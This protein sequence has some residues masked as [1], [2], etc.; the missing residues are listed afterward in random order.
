MQ[1]FATPG[2]SLQQVGGDCPEGWVVMQEQRPQIGFVALADGSW[3]EPLQLV[4]A[5]CTRRQ[6]LL[7][8]LAFG[9]KRADIEAQIAAIEDEIE[10]EEAQIEYEANDWERGNPRLQQMWIAL[11]GAP[12]QLDDLYRLAVTL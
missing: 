2:E 9:F 5:S 4:P 7:A 11:G 1:V 3:A 8:L 10:K 6:G 12:A